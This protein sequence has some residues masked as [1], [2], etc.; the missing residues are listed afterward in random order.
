MNLQVSESGIDTWLKTLVTE[1]AK[2]WE[3]YKE[4]FFIRNDADGVLKASFVIGYALFTIEFMNETH[5]RM[6][7]YNSVA[8]VQA[9]LPRLVSERY[10]PTNLPGF[11]YLTINSARKQYMSASMIMKRSLMTKTYNQL[12]KGMVD[13]VHEKAKTIPHITNVKDVF[14]YTGYASTSKFTQAFF[15][16][17]LVMFG[18][19]MFYGWRQTSNGRQ[20][21][22]EFPGSCNVQGVINMYLFKKHGLLH[23]IVYTP[24]GVTG[25]RRT[26]SINKM[27]AQRASGTDDVQFCHH[28]WKLIG[29]PT[30]SSSGYY[31]AHQVKVLRSHVDAFDVLTLTPIFRAI[32]RLKRTGK[33]DRVKYIEMLLDLINS[34]IKAFVTGHLMNNLAGNRYTSTASNVVP[35]RPNNSITHYKFKLFINNH[36][37]YI[38]N[39]RPRDTLNKMKEKYGSN[40]NKF[41]K[42]KNVLN[43]VTLNKNNIFSQVNRKNLTNKG[44]TQNEVNIAMKHLNLV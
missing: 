42:I 10:G 18:W 1:T 37:K 22:T 29:E 34:N 25:V 28:A 6:R 30:N 35:N 24:H 39:G 44:L 32:Q 14:K 5:E 27:T 36:R 33:H 40:Y 26:G 15:Y 19:Y 41:V 8:Q 9:N 12:E 17:S 20:I 43:K 16:H 21:A 38:E 13:I 2:K 31:P 23:K 7:M 11:N 3:R 4:D